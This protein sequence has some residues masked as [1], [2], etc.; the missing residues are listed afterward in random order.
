MKKFY[1]DLTGCDRAKVPFNFIIGGRGTGKT[2]TTLHRGHELFDHGVAELNIEPG[3]R[4][5]YL[6]R[7]EKTIQSISEENLNPFK[8]LN[9]DFGW[10]TNAKY[11]SNI[12]IGNFTENDNLLGYAAAV[13]TFSKLRGAD[14]SDVSIGIYDEFI[15]EKNEKTIKGECDAFLN[16]YETMNRNRENDGKPPIIMYFLSNAQDI[17][18]ELLAELGLIPVI[19]KMKMTRQN[20]ITIRER[21]IH[22]ELIQ[23]VG[24]SEFKKQSAIGKLTRGTKFYDFAIENE[25]SY[26]SF[27]NIVKQDLKHYTPLI[28]VGNVFIY[29]SKSNVCFYACKSATKCPYVYGND[30]IPMFKRQFGLTVGAACFSNRMMFESYD[31]KM[32]L[33]NIFTQYH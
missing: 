5:I 18:S 25:F 17:E 13:S 29:K 31:V 15:K 16:A 6:R 19:E 23:G 9:T 3:T 30:N 32:Y 10:S 11:Y 14:L 21:G 33:R 27:D 20:A 8:K 1:W 12:S 4:F 22:I 26:N 24:I 7:T 28:Q 2:Y